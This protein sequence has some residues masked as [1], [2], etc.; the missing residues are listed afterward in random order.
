MSLF[1][2]EDKTA[3]ALLAA[4]TLG[5]GD[6][7]DRLAR[8]TWSR[9]AEP[10]DAGAGR[11]IRELGA[12]AALEA[13]R[14]RDVEALARGGADVAETESAL[15]RWTP[16]LNASSVEITLTQSARFGVRLLTPADDLW[17][18]QLADLGD[19]APTAL[20]IRGQAEKLTTLGKSVALV[21]ARAATGYGEHVTIEVAA[22]LTDR[23]VAIVSG[24]AYGIDGAAHRA[25]LASGGTTVAVLAGGLDRFYPAGHEALLERIAGTGVL[26]SEVPVGTAPTKWRFLSRGRLIA[27]LSSATVVVEA[28]WRSGSLG[29]AGHAA[30]LGRPIGAVPGPVTSAA[31]AGTHRLIRDHGATLVTTAEE[32]ATLLG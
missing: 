21:G 7:R 17:P 13:L 9:I 27:G 6:D 18:A 29:I 10:G 19:H 11:A 5:D 12:A 15:D 24:G 22:G 2:I 30:L 4:I 25:A 8:V 16:R 23:G 31:S 14:D 26:V 20:W 32:I 28:G 3:R 1:D